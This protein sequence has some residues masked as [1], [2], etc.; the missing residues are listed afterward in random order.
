[1]IQ[2]SPTFV[3]P[4]DYA[5]NALSMGIYNVVPTQ[6][7]DCIV[8]AGPIAVGGQLVQGVHQ[9]LAASEP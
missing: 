2:R 4:T 9:M 5:F 7:A 1:M 8:N 6:V 3:L